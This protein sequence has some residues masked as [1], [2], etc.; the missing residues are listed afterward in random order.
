MSRWGKPVSVMLCSAS[1]DAADGTETFVRCAGQGTAVHERS[2]L[3]DLEAGRRAHGV[4]DGEAIGGECVAFGRGEQGH[5]RRQAVRDLFR[6]FCAHKP[7]GLGDGFVLVKVIEDALHDIGAVVLV[8][9]AGYGE[10]VGERDPG[11]GSRASR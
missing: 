4:A 11:P 6:R 2:D 10:E 9:K 8:A 7:V 3:G 1:A 5:H